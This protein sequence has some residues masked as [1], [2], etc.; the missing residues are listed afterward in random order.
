MRVYLSL[1][2]FWIYAEVEQWQNPRRRRWSETLLRLSNAKFRFWILPD[3]I[4]KSKF[5]VNKL[6][7][8]TTIRIQCD[9][10]SVMESTQARLDIVFISHWEISSSHE[11]PLVFHYLYVTCK[12]LH[13]KLI[14]Y[15]IGCAFLYF[16][17]TCDNFFS[18]PN[19]F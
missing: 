7:V 5:I 14:M 8:S 12:L 3:S 1:S 16:V 13:H 10:Y 6:V 9:M 2:Q 11:K 18:F 17:H 15:H 4:F 19:G